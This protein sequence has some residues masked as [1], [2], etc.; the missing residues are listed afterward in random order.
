MRGVSVRIFPWG[1]DVTDFQ[2]RAILIATVED[3]V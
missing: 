3:S 2:S 1:A